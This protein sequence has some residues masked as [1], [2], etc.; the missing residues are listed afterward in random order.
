MA[1]VEIADARDFGEPQGY[2]TGILP[3]NGK[4]LYP[5][6][7]DELNPV[8]TWPHNLTVYEQMRWSDPIIVAIWNLLRS[9]MLKLNWHVDPAGCENAEFVQMIADQFGLPVMGAETGATP[10]AATV[11][12]GKHLGQAI[13]VFTFGFLPFEVTVELVN[14]MYR[15]TGLELRH[16]RTILRPVTDGH[17]RL[18]EVYQAGLRDPIP[19]DRVCWYSV[20]E[21]GD[22]KVGVSLLRGIYKPWVLKDKLE[23]VGVLAM[24]RNGMGIPHAHL[25]AS[26]GDER[27]NQALA[28]MKALRSGNDAALVTMGEDVVEILGVQGKVLDPLPLLEYLNYQMVAAFSMQFLMLG[29]TSTG[30]RSLGEV[31]IDAAQDTVQAFV[32]MIAET[33]TE[34]VVR[35]QAEWSFGAGA[36]YPR[37]NP[38]MVGADG[39]VPIADLVNLINAGAI[40]N[41]ASLEKFLRERSNLPEMDDTDEHT[42]VGNGKNPLRPFPQHA[43]EPGSAQLRRADDPKAGAPLRA[44]GATKRRK[45]SEDGVTAT[46]S[47]AAGHTHALA[48][49]ISNVYP[50][51]RTIAQ[52]ASDGYDPTAG[53][54]QA[55]ITSAINSGRQQTG[56]DALEAALA[57]IYKTAGHYGAGVAYQEVGG[58]P[59]TDGP[60]LRQLEAAVSARVAGIDETTAS[61]MANSLAEGLSSGLSVDE[62]AGNLDGILLDSTRAATIATT[63]ARFGYMAAK[64]D[65]WAAAGATKFHW[66]H[67]GACA[68]GPCAMCSD[69]LAASPVNSPSDWPNGSAP[70][71]PHCDCDVYASP[72]VSSGSGA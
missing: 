36:P 68:H 45:E 70:L 5:V 25:P 69:S 64:L 14:G 13:E 52:N 57:A 58:V 4:L 63:E 42:G 51:P 22:Q 50:D 26:A 31:Q 12:F 8:L 16:P 27:R 47:I 72:P 60:H 35:R 38:G 15:L 34:Q 24:E 44:G 46:A 41:D 19:G 21:L 23:R 6:N 65:T 40:T 61:R 1:T 10:G 11:P 20:N 53:A 48:N 39:D 33:I 59:V 43:D 67:A 55:S 3:V 62:M 37:I 17:G 49:A 71:H 30:A 66:V 2:S 7:I 9:S 32:N 28:L 56:L 18:L 54:E 29:S